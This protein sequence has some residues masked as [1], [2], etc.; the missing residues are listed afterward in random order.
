MEQPE[1]FRFKCTKCGNCCTDSNTVINVT[2]KDILR[3][4]EG[5]RLTIDEIIEILSFYLFKEPPTND[6]LTKLVVPPIETEEGL[7]F[8]GLRRAKLKKYSCYFFDTEKK[9]C[10]IYRLRPYFCRTFPF[11]FRIIFNPEDTTRAKIKMSYTNKSIEYC[12]GIDG[13]SPLINE[14]DWI[15]VGKETIEAMNN[16]NILIKH[17]NAAVHAGKIEPSVRN[18]ILTIL[19]LNQKSRIKTS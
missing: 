12:P 13:K 2:Y 8:I 1:E 15:Q 17:W 18:Y 11:T 19:N 9:T 14:D 10:K 3:I 16:D 5:L 4:K 6:Q 7:A